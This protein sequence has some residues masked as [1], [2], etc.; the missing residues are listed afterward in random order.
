MLER[1]VYSRGVTTV[2]FTVFWI[3]I[4]VIG[5][6]LQW[7]SMICEYVLS[8]AVAFFYIQLRKAEQKAAEPIAQQN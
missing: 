5:G 2:L 4:L 6:S 3:V 8:A 1:I 7:M